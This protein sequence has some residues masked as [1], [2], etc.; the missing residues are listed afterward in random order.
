MSYCVNCGV[1]LAKSEKRCP[2]CNTKVINPNK[3]IEENIPAYS[4]K[5][6]NFKKINYKFLSK[7]VLLVLVIISSIVVICDLLFD[8]EISWSIYVVLSIFYLGTYILSPGFNNIYVFVFI[9]LFSTQFLM[10]VIAYLNS[11]LH[12]YW[13]LLFPF[14]LIVWLYIGLCAFLTR[15]KKMNILK[16]FTISMFY[17]SIV[18]MSIETVID[19]Y[20]R[21][22]VCYNWSVYAALPITIIGI[23]LLILSY[24]DKIVE[25]IK[26]RMF[27]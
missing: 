25:E 18:L 14:I 12:L 19:L 8:Y 21:K 20:A 11:F 3:H 22:M 9:E 26:Q 23:M 10:F 15:R 6:E 7:L 16:K 17:S 27:I 4:S 1:K 5:I 2:L 24:N 13:Y